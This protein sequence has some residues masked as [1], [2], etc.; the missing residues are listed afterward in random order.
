[1]G[2]GTVK[3]KNFLFSDFFCGMRHC[4]SNNYR[5]EGVYGSEL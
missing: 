1:M 5:K 4:A 3:I 2:Q